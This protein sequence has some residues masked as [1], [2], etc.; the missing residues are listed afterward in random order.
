MLNNT[1]QDYFDIYSGIVSGKDSVYKNDTLGNIEVLSGENT[2]DKYIYIEN[3][4]CE[5]DSINQYLL[6]YKEL[7][8]ERNICE[9]NENNWFEWGA[10]RNIKIM[11][12]HAGKECIYIHNLTRNRKVAFV[13][14]VQYFGGNLLMMIPK[15]K[16]NLHKIVD[17]LNSD[18]FIQC[19][20]YCGRFKITRQQIGDCYIPSPT[21]ELNA[22]KNSKK[23]T[24]NNETIQ[25]FATHLYTEVLDAKPNN[26]ISF[27]CDSIFSVEGEKKIIE[28]L[29]DIQENKK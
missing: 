28:L 29:E 2:S 5:N 13:G 15:Q 18:E 14:K 17:Y 24:A 16:C 9:F 8:L 27:I 12:L 25:A 26:I 1:F 20:T 7:L 3:Y 6:E 11:E 4:P 19:F 22:M 23:I 10:P 21:N